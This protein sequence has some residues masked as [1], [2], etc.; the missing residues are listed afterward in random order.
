MFTQPLMYKKIRQQDHVLA[1]YVT[2][3]VGDGVITQQEYEVIILSYCMYF[4]VEDS[5]A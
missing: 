3:L 1:K 5:E 4:S 2:K